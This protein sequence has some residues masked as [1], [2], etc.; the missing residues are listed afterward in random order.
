MRDFSAIYDDNDLCEDRKMRTIRS[1]K[2][3]K[4]AEQSAF[5]ATRVDGRVN[6]LR[7]TKNYSK[8]RSLYSFVFLSERTA[9]RTIYAFAF[10]NVARALVRAASSHATHTRTPA[11]VPRSSERRELSGWLR[12]LVVYFIVHP[13]LGFPLALNPAVTLLSVLSSGLERGARSVGRL[14]EMTRSR[15]EADA[16]C[17]RG[18]AS[19]E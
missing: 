17:G 19:V 14:R 18:L 7:L 12:L 6:H 11:Y 16:D 3:Q 8:S 9:L 13:P 4:L 10:S 15:S 2:L 1:F 5:Y